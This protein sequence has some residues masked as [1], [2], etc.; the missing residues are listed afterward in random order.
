MYTICMYQVKKKRKIFLNMN[1]K[2]FNAKL[3]FLFLDFRYVARLLLGFVGGAAFVLIPIMVA[4]IA[5]DSIRGTLSTIL[6]IANYGGA[7]IGIAVGYF[8]TYELGLWLS[9]LF[10]ILFFALYAFMPETPYYLMKSN[11]MEVCLAVLLL[12]PI[13]TI[14]V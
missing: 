1:M 14:F 4:E 13:F 12:S 7:L 11:R 10:P 6:V 3:L 8:I 5:E 9:M 2:L